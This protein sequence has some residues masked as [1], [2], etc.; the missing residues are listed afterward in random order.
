[1]R[2]YKLDIKS[3]PSILGSR[4]VFK[5]KNLDNILKSNGYTYDELFL[6]Y[7]KTVL[8]FVDIVLDMGKERLYFYSSRF[9]SPSELDI[10]IKEQREKDRIL[11]EVRWLKS[12]GAFTE[13]KKQ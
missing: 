6:S 12:I 1:M 7:R 11:K 5:D 4:N 2:N 8:P 9:F 3:E 13:K 10:V